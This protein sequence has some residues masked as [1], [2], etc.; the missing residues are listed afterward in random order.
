MVELHLSF[1]YSNICVSSATLRVQAGVVTGLTLVI[2][3]MIRQ[4]LLHAF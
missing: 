4:L 3:R 1:H 2:T